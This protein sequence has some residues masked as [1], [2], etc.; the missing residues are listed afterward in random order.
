MLWQPTTANIKCHKA[1]M[2]DTKRKRLY[3]TFAI[4]NTV[5]KITSENYKCNILKQ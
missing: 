5:Q 2:S 4:K 3:V 1:I